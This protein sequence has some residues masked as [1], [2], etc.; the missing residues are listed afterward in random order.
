MEAR[1]FGR[2]G[3]PEKQYKNIPIDDGRARTSSNTCFG[4]VCGDN[5]PQT[6]RA[7]R[8]P[9]MH[10]TDRNEKPAITSIGRDNDNVPRMPAMIITGVLGA[11]VTMLTLMPVSTMKVSSANQS[12]NANTQAI[13]CSATFPKHTRPRAGKSQLDNGCSG[14]SL[15]ALSS[16]LPNSSDVIQFNTATS[17]RPSTAPYPARRNAYG[18]VRMPAPM[19]QLIMLL[20][21][22][23]TLVPCTLPCA[24]SAVPSSA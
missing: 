17:T 6:K 22:C 14:C 11:P 18:T 24:R 2:Q 4:D 1:M 5:V 15:A 16:A 21:V 10:Q 9:N 8:P 12:S 3:R 13:A 23:C 20:A 19:K 7:T